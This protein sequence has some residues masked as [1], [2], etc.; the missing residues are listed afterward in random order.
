MVVVCVVGSGCVV[1]CGVGG[2]VDDGGGGGG[3]SGVDLSSTTKGVFRNEHFG[4]PVGRS[5]KSADGG[6]LLILSYLY[7]RIHVVGLLGVLN[8]IVTHFP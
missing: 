5:V 2:V 6:G 1:D 7:R 8:C 4:V 3:G